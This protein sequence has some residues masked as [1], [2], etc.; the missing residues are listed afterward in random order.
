MSPLRCPVCQKQFKYA[1]TGGS[2][3]MSGA[4]ETPDCVKEASQTSLPLCSTSR[5]RDFPSSKT[6]LLGPITKV[7]PEVPDKT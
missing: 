5:P 3:L 2:G 1:V 7:E 6:K 4:C